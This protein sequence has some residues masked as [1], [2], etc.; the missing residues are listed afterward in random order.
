MSLVYSLKEDHSFAI[1]RE[2]H[3]P[4]FFIL[5]WSTFFLPTSFD[6]NDAVPCPLI[7]LLEDNGIVLYRKASSFFM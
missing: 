7:G 3:L 6:W 2:K 1:Y 4:T 5:L